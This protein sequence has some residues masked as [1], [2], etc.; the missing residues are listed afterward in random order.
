MS[1]RATETERDRERERRECQIEQKSKSIKQVRAATLEPGKPHAGN[2][3]KCP[4]NINEI[5]NINILNK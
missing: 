1:E 3:L 4:K 2:T 5:T